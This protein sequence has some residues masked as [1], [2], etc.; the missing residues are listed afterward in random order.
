M[1]L[2]M[3]PSPSFFFR[4]GMVLTSYQALA[5]RRNAA[6]GRGVSK[7]KIMASALPLAMTGPNTPLFES[8]FFQPFRHFLAIILGHIQRGGTT[9]NGVQFKDE[10]I[11]FFKC[12][13]ACM[14]VLHAAQ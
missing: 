12:P 1:T 5:A 2:F 7:R 10:I 11:E 14:G 8:L 4:I 9:A 13:V 3:R 6:H